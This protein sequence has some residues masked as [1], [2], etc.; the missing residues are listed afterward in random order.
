V[1]AIL[2]SKQLLKCEW[3]YVVKSK[4]YYALKASWVNELNMDHAQKI[5]EVVHN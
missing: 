3:E 1:E 5:T 4:D 2:N